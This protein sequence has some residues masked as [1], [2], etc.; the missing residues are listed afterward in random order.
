MNL[1]TLS[2]AIGGSA[3]A[4]AAYIA[5]RNKPNYMVEVM[6]DVQEN[7]ECLIIGDKHFVGRSFITRNVGV[8]C[9]KSKG[10]Q[11]YVLNR[12]DAPITG[13]SIYK[14]RSNSSLYEDCKKCSASTNIGYFWHNPLTGG[15]IDIK[16]IRWDEHFPSV[17][18]VNEKEAPTEDPILR[19]VLEL[20]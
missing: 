10:Y 6:C 12:E 11:I 15:N 13:I 14:T 8:E 18:S 9:L 20:F 4:L 17:P 2:A 1:T 16:V 5:Y 7:I 19:Y 3:V